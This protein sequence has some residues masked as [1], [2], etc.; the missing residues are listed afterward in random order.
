MLEGS[1]LIRSLEAPTKRVYMQRMLSKCQNIV[2]V[3]VVALTEENK[4][5]R[6]KL[7]ET[8]LFGKKHTRL[9]AVM[10][11]LVLEKH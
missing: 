3:V 7:S 1:I 5:K 9:S 2:V 10:Y 8:F 11:N 4:N 6:E